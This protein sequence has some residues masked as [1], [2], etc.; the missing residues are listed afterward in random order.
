MFRRQTTGSVVCVSCGYLVGVNDATCYHC[1][2][3]NPGL[4]GFAPALRRLG[5]DMGFVPFVIG[6]CGVLYVLTWVL[7]GASIGGGGL[8]DFLPVGQNTLVVFGASGYLPIF[9]LGRWWTVFSA[10]WLHANLLHIVF[11]MMWIRQLAPAVGDIY[12]PGRMVI[13][14]TIAGATGFA[15][16][17]VAGPLLGFLPILHGAPVTVGASAPIF[18]LL[19]ALVHYGRRGGSSAVRSQAVYYAVILFAFGFIVSGVDNYAHAGGF[20][21][22]YLASLVLDPLKPE[23]IDHII[24]A[25]GCI[26]VSILS[27]VVSILHALSLQ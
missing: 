9:A 16:T 22:G 17:S 21:G 14:Y 20:L 7:S 13:I 25:L 18:G 27:V 23:R 10:G 4:W 2:R 5:H 12:G 15:L 6:A 8:M 19:G 11:N 3:R 24:V 26:V 1:G